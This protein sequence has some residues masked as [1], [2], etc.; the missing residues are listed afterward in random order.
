[1][2]EYIKSDL[3]RYAGKT[4]F[5]T[6]LVYF[7]TRYSFRYIVILRLCNSS[8][9]LKF[10]FYPFHKI[11]SSKRIQ[12]PFY[13]QIGYGFYIGHNGPVVINGSACIGDNCT[14]MQFTTIGSEFDKA[15]I[16]GDNV[17]I[18]PNVSIVENVIIGSNVTIG[19]GSVVTKDIPNNAT[20]AG[21][22]A[23]VLHYEKPGRL[24]KR[25]WD[26]RELYDR[27]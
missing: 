17:Y 12:I 10:I 14:I 15:A 21:N 25:L 11:M 5:I 1:M 8:K 9:F 7:F 16:I 4:D 13:T 19:S 23:K 26:E 2:N 3:Y 27:Y 22:Y 24:Q 20:V 6:F 18:G